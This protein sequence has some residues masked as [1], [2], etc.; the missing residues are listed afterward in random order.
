MGACEITQLSASNTPGLND[1]H[2]FRI[3]H[4]SAWPGLPKLGSL[5]NESISYH[6]SVSASAFVI[7]KTQGKSLSTSRSV[8]LVRQ[9]SSALHLIILYGRD[10]GMAKSQVV[11]LSKLWSPV[12]SCAVNNYL[13][14]TAQLMTTHSLPFK[15]HA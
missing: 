6:Y 5:I 15:L 8:S 13:L 1:R 7:V 4:S 10:E 2:H 3:L 12:M 9:C 14:F 11:I